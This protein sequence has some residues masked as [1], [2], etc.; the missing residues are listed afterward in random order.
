MVPFQKNKRLPT[1]PKRHKPS[2]RLFL[3]LSVRSPGLPAGVGAQATEHRIET[4]FTDR[5]APVLFAPIPT[6]IPGHGPSLFRESI[7]I[8]L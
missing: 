3:V 2:T 4:R 8:S 5:G 7:A 1:T 6:N